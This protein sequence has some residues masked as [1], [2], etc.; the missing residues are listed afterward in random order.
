MLG[1]GGGGA[2]PS[3]EIAVEIIGVALYGCV[4]MYVRVERE[5]ERV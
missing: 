5:R 1:G 3:P 4:S 2:R